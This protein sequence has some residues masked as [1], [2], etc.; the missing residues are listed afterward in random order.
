MVDAPDLDYV[1]AARLYSLRERRRERW[2]GQPAVVAEGDFPAAALARLRAYGA[3][4]GLDDFGREGAA[5]DAAD[6]VR[7]EDL[8]G[9]LHL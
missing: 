1:G 4:D 3:A 5:N 6:V 9:K 2:S 7:L 8:G